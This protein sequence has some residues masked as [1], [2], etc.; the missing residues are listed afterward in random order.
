MNPQSKIFKC[1]VCEQSFNTS[2]G[3][4]AH[5]N[6]KYSH[7]GLQRNELNEMVFICNICNKPFSSQRSLYHH[8]RV[9]KHAIDGV[10]DVGEAME[11]ASEEA[12]DVYSSLLKRLLNGHIQNEISHE[13]E[14][15]IELSIS[16]ALGRVQD[17]VKQAFRSVCDEMI[18]L[19]MTTDI[20]HRDAWE[21]VR[22]TT[23]P[24]ENELLMTL[25][26]DT[27]KV[28]NELKRDLEN[29]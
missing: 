6:A 27:F 28:A 24:F 25:M 1:D 11:S 26:H 7:D 29:L 9:A 22:K 5:V 19:Y 17:A 20:E 12:Q 8:R 4:S 13:K 15:V 23:E 14:R 21:R 3:L 10:A 18:P 2:H 16:I